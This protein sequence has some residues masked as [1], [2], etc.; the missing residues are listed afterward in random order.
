M[1]GGTSSNDGDEG[2]TMGAD[3]TTS[4]SYAEAFAAEDELAYRARERSLALRIPPVTPGTAAALTVL[5]AT[6]RP[7]TVVEVGTGAGVSG[8]ALLASSAL[9]RFGVL[10]AGLRSA[11]DPR[12]TIEPQ[13]AR[14][15]ARRAAGVV[16]DAIT[17][18]G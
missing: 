12:Y 4:W 9:T 8:L 16:D 1:Q 3:K 10:E 11:E 5:A 2:R 17:T 13:K 18:A 15:A 6:A 7:S 14:L